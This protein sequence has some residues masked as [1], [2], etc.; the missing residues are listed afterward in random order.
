MDQQQQLTREYARYCQARKLERELHNLT[1][2]DFRVVKVVVE[3]WFLTNAQNGDPWI[4]TV[5]VDLSLLNEL[6]E[7]KI[8]EPE[9]ILVKIKQVLGSKLPRVGALKFN[10]TQDENQVS[11]TLTETQLWSSG[12]QQ[13]YTFKLL[14]SRVTAL[15]QKYQSLKN[16]GDP[17]IAI[18]IVALRY[19]SIWAGRRQWAAS[20][21][22]IQQVGY[23]IEA[24]SSP[25]NC[26]S[27]LFWSDAQF[28][29]LFP[30]VEMVFG[31]LG[32]FLNVDFPSGSCVF[33]HPARVY[34]LYDKIIDRC[35]D[36][37][38]KKQCS[39]ALLMYCYAGNSFVQR[40]RGCGWLREERVVDMT[41]Y[42]SE[43]PFDG[44]T[45][46]SSNLKEKEYIFFLSSE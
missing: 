5:E 46:N 29:S 44:S 34:E 11:F 3:R 36:Q 8:P 35:L 4:S 23:P 24:M 9:K 17:L 13:Q 14:L 43:N 37:C 41:Q 20:R 1:R 7:R 27:L 19:D 26:Q 10:M 33:V 45:V 6:V 18:L 2:N 39:F 25:L 40:L 38:S 12:R 31:S 42:P 22:L 32:S 15:T 21:E 28:C 16:T 30:E